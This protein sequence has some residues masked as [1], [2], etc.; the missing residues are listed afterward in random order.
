MTLKAYNETQLEFIAIEP[1]ENLSAFVET[2]SKEKISEIDSKINLSLDIKDGVNVKIPKFKFDYELSLKEDLMNLGIN[3]AFDK[4]KADFSKMGD[5]KEKG[6]YLFVSDGIH[7]A[8]I[9]F[10]EKGARAAAVTVV[11]NK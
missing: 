4:I 1:H 9:D 2:V 6:E 8:E 7:K 10:T 11:N 5:A 3:D